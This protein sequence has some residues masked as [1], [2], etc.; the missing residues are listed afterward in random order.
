MRKPAGD[1]L[2]GS[3][4][5][6][7]T[8]SGSRGVVVYL[9]TH[10]LVVPIPIVHH[11][12]HRHR[13]SNLHTVS[14]RPLTTVARLPTSSFAH[15]LA[16]PHPTPALL[17][18]PPLPA[19]SSWFT[20]TS[21]S[22]E[23][24]Q[25]NVAYFTQYPDPIVEVEHAS[26]LRFSRIDLPLSFFLAYLNSP[27]SSA[28]ATFLPHGDTLYLAQQMPPAFLLPSLPLPSV[29][30]P[31]AFSHSTIWLG[32]T[33][34]VTPLH[35]DPDDNVLYQLAGS[36]LVKLWSASEGEV[37]LRR[38][39]ELAGKRGSGAGGKLR[40]EE[41]MRSG[42]GGERDHLESA[43]WGL[44]ERGEA[45]GTGTPGS[46]AFAAFR[47][48]AWEARLEPGDAL[49]IPRGWWHAVR[50]VAGEAVAVAPGEGTGS[51]PPGGKRTIT[52]SVNW[53][54]R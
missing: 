53:W 5:L 17:S 23:K 1:C 6:P 35:A 8:P 52:A 34:T 9:S 49:F 32:L 27:P 47:E 29:I 16:A 40:G 10:P 12:M 2:I 51:A 46:D 18:L 30:P 42:P 44:D 48:N 15:H 28:A 19:L 43:V 7:G 24:Q 31:S 54:F 3:G 4:A 38:V 45:T 14:R 41:M 50:G 25:I 36:K 22:S 20:K 11:L 21:S 13:I 39:R 37:I 33:P 26:S